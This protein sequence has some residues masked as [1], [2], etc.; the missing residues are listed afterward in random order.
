MHLDAALSLVP[1]SR[2]YNPPFQFEG[3]FRVLVHPIP[4]GLPSSYMTVYCV[5]ALYV[6]SYLPVQA[7]L[8]IRQAN[9]LF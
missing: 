3:F 9:Q 7:G 6:E 1:N 5:S 2:L 4:A 8:V